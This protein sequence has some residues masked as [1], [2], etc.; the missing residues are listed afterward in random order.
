MET[1]ADMEDYLQDLLNPSNPK[2]AR[3]IQ[4]LLKKWHP[5]SRE[6]EQ[7]VPQGVTVGVKHCKLFIQTP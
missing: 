7:H 5:K 6:V 4:E 1:K 2:H 3:F